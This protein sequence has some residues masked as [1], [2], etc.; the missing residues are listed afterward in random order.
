MPPLNIR[1]WNGKKLVHVIDQDLP[2]YCREPLYVDG[3]APDS[4]HT[5]TYAGPDPVPD[6]N[7]IKQKIQQ[8]VPNL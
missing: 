3:S 1:R 8:E 7:T 5:W 2:T 4:T 6:A